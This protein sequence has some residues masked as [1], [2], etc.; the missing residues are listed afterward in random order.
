MSSKA[1]YA[2]DKRAARPK[3][4]GYARVGR[5]T[6]SG[7]GARGVG[8]F[9]GGVLFGSP[10]CICYNRVCFCLLPNVAKKTQRNR[11]TR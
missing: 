9:L 2:L 11:A 10:A 8:T 4:R 6:V 3:V 7:T 5:V 1:C